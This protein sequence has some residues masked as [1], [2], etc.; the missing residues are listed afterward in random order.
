[1][2]VRNTLAAVDLVFKN[3]S[4]QITVSQNLPNAILLSGVPDCSLRMVVVKFTSSSISSFSYLFIFTLSFPFTH[5]DIS[6]LLHDLIIQYQ[7][8]HI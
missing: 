3:V 7:T 8:Y 1:M 5:P 6:I 4:L 2:R